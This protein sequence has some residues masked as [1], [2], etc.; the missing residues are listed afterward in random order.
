MVH[1][2]PRSLQW[3]VFPDARVPILECEDCQRLCS[4][5]PPIALLLC[6]C[7][8][9]FAERD[10]CLAEELIRSPGGPVAVVAGSNVTMPYGMA[11]LSREIMHEYFQMRDATL[12]DLVLYAKRGTMAGYD[13]A[14]WALAH[15][16]TTALAPAAVRPKEERL[17]HLQLFNLL[18]DPTMPL[19]RP[20]GLK[21]AAPNSATAGQEIDVQGECPIDGRCTIELVPWAAVRPLPAQRSRYDGTRAG[22]AQFD[23]VY[24]AAN[25]PQIAAVAT[26]A[27]DGRFEARLRLPRQAHGAC[28]LRAYVEGQK[29]FAV[30]TC[31][32]QIEPN[33][34]E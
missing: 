3:A 16:L 31:D 30:G 11:A 5:A 24:R 9:A 25:E 12:G 32:V 34:A 21:L 28:F 27:A 19:R 15:A 13:E 1:G 22:R 14:L 8:G 4:H 23:A 2:A 17:E 33:S 20:Q 29:D 6:C 7:A 26:S 18:G 10:D